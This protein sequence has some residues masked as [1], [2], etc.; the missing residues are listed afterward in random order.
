MPKVAAGMLTDGFQRLY[1]DAT[2]FEPFST[3][4]P[5]SFARVLPF[6]PDDPVM[7]DSGLLG[8]EMSH[9]AVRSDLT[10]GEV[11]DAYARC[12]LLS[13]EDAANVKSV[14]DLYGADFF[15]LMGLVYANAGMCIGALRWYREF[16]RELE[17]QGPEAALDSEGVYASVGYCLYALGLYEEAVAW[18]KSCVGPCLMADAICEALLDYEAQRVGGRL[19]CVERVGL[20]TR[21]TLSTSDP[22]QVSESTP[23]L[24][25]AL[26]TYAPDQET[27][28]DWI[29]ADASLPASL[30]SAEAPAD[31]REALFQPVKLVRDISDLPRH[32]LNLIFA[33]Y[34]RAEA[35]REKDFFRLA[36]QLLSEAA[37]LE[38]SA[39]F[40][41][42]RLQTL[43]P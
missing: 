31:D 23:R 26:K 19:R 42:S 30:E 27:Y 5:I 41:Q 1:C 36:R 9:L 28:L 10:R 18:T 25:A 38:P 24:K 21:Y 35:L 34:A 6:Q 39:V 15:E 8:A 17:A 3:L 32:K 11:I 20:R 2:V 12:G 16:I 7:D 29:A 13:A 4:H 33:S 14:I 40:I 43:G 37:Q 22:S